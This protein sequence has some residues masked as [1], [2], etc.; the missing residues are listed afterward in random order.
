M[1]ANN[2]T[3]VV[4]FV[5]Q[6][7]SGDPWLQVLFSAFFLLLYLMALAGNVI[8]VMAIGLNPSLHTPMYFFLTNLAFLDIL[9]TSTVLPKLLEGLV[10]TRSTMSYGGCMAQLFFLTWFLGAE[11]LLLTAMAYDRYVAICQPLHYHTLMSWPICILLA[12]GVW[13]VS[14]VSTSVHTGLMARLYFC[15]PNQIHHFLCEVPTLLLLS[16]SPTML[17]NVM[18]VIADVYFG[19]VNFLLTMLSYGCIIA[20]IVRMRSAAGKRKAFSTC[21]SHLL[22]VTLYYS[23]VIYT[24][25]LPGSGSSSENGKVV[26]LLYTVVSPT[27][28]PL[29]YSLRNK[30]VNMAL[31]RVFACTW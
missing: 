8:I 23:T 10:A 1:A 25:I 5:L 29:I 6:G 4:E 26:A 2:H 30:D 11:L 24:Y 18:I 31:G 16:C 15:G 17:N 20:S 14:V 21:S 27:L 7:F 12:G 28:N 9:C 22:V 3:A 19:V 13:V